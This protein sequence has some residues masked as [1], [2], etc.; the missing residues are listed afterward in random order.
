MF[1]LEIFIG[2][3]ILGPTTLV[4]LLSKGENGRLPRITYS[5]LFGWWHGAFQ[6][7][8]AASAM[9]SLINADYN[10]EIWE[11]RSY[12]RNYGPRGEEG[13]VSNSLKTA[14]LTPSK[15]RVKLILKNKDEK[16]DDIVCDISAYDDHI[17][18]GAV[19]SWRARHKEV[20]RRKK[21]LESERIINERVA[22]NYISTIEMVE[23]KILGKEEAT[24]ANELR[25]ILPPPDQPLSEQQT[26]DLKNVV[27]IA[28]TT[29][30]T[31]DY[32]TVT[33]LSKSR[34]GSR[35]RNS[36]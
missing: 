18:M 13:L 31:S 28:S 3:M 25:A 15:G 29:S 5:A 16:K 23:K 6:P 14:V 1:G 21:D 17:L 11:W 22:A 2:A 24:T 10:C 12:V 9:A 27:Y 26:K 20:E 32:S 35:K 30:S 33:S 19:N 36:S 34:S 8:N 4:N 7:E